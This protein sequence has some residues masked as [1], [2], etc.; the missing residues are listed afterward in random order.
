MTPKQQRF[1]DEYL[2]DCNG[3]RAYKTA[4]PHVKSDGVAA[5]NAARLLKNAKVSEYINCRL[6]E[7]SSGKVADTKEIMEYLTGVMRGESNAE[8]IAVHGFGYDKVQKAPDEKERLKAAELLGKRYQLFTDR[9]NVE[10]DFQV[11]FTG[12]NDLAE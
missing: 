12:E 1:A 5:A 7:I 11:N 10:G 6:E 4:Y 8:I 9:V 2:I 3:T